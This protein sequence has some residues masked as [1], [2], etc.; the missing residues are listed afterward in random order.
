MSLTPEQLRQNAAAMIAF[1]DEKP[2]ECQRP[3][4]AWVRTDSLS[5]I[6][7]IPHRPKPWTLP[8]PPKGKQWHRT[9]WTEEMLPG[10]YRPLLLG[11]VIQ[12]D[13]Q[14]RDSGGEWDDVMASI[15][16]V[17]DESNNHRRTRRPLPAEP[18]TRPWSKPEDVPGPVCFLR[19]STAK[20]TWQVVVGASR[21]GVLLLVGA[22]ESPV[23]R[24]AAWDTVSKHWQHSTDRRTWL[25][26]TVTQ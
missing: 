14:V 9:D 24:M 4:G 13:D 22:E 12:G 15:G 16:G 19:Y 3:S 23:I 8:A 7:T 21:M 20:D 25:P 11:E 5:G 18:V 1:A 26:C 2:I 17:V 10:G 6:E